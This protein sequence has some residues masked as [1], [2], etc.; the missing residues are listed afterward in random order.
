M[1][2]E[3]SNWYPIYNDKFYIPE[4]NILTF[5]IRLY[6]EMELQ[7]RPFYSSITHKSKEQWQSGIADLSNIK[8]IDNTMQSDNPSGYAVYTSGVIETNM[9]ET[10]KLQISVFANHSMAPGFEYTL[11]ISI[12]DSS[13]EIADMPAWVAVKSPDDVFIQRKYIRYRISIPNQSKIIIYSVNIDFYSENYRYE[14]APEV[15]GLRF[16]GVPYE[17]DRYTQIYK[18]FSI[19]VPMDGLYHQVTEYSLQSMVHTELI[20]MGYYDYRLGGITVSTYDENIRLSYDGV[21]SSKLMAMSSIIRNHYP[22]GTY[23]G[24]SASSGRGYLKPIPVAGRP[25]ILRKD[26]YDNGRDGYFTHVTFLDKDNKTTLTNTE[27][28]ISDGRNVLVLGYKGID[29][30]TMIILRYDNKA[31]MEANVNGE[32]VYW[33]TVIDNFVYFIDNLERGS[34]YEVSYKLIDSFAVDYNEFTDIGRAL[35]IIHTRTGNQDYT[36]MR[37]W[38]EVKQ[39]DAWFYANKIEINPLY[40]PLNQG[41]VFLTDYERACSSIE[42]HRSPEMLLANGRETRYFFIRTLDEIGN[43]IGN[44]GLQI[45][46]L[47]GKLFI[48]SNI[49]NLYGIVC[50]QYTVPMESDMDPD[51]DDW[52]EILSVKAVDS[53]VSYEEYIRLYRPGSNI[54]INVISNQLSVDEG[55][56]IELF[57]KVFDDALYP[58]DD[59]EVTA[60]LLQNTVSARTGPDGGCVININAIINHKNSYCRIKLVCRNQHKYLNIK[61]NEAV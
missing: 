34:F 37:A 14:Y 25:V 55:D 35:V 48:R 39:D 38:F 26:N 58:Q 4:R 21:S 33:D 57:V 32:R 12:A 47:H 10:D 15:R 50:A 3:P 42:I 9:L 44:I 29:E 45:N 46:V 23:I 27:Y 41:F 13:F 8:I 7:I 61:V 16:T 52:I 51:T 43:P 24:I 1:T 31:D 56:N 20:Q 54:N 5:Q 11:E 36:R 59:A 17:F 18:T 6:F 40:N 19:S 49:T 60:Y 22:S 53:N 28:L 2:G 30:Q